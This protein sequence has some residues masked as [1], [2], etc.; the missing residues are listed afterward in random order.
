MYLTKYVYGLFLVIGLC[1][2]ISVSS[3]QNSTRIICQ[4]SALQDHE[5]PADQTVLVSQESQVYVESTTETLFAAMHEQLFRG[6][7]VYF[8]ILNAYNLVFNFP[9]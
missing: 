4:S 1:A 3:A 2:N 5:Q 7:I 9:S 6:I 8:L